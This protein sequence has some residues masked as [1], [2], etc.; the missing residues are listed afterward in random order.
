MEK[1][2][3]LPLF[4]T[5]NSGIHQEAVGGKARIPSTQKMGAAGTQIDVPLVYKD[6]S[7][8]ASH[9]DGMQVS[10][11][12]LPPDEIVVAVVVTDSGRPPYKESPVSGKRMP[13]K[14][15]GCGNP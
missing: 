13:R 6:A 12:M 14:R 5:Q 1:V 3:T 9:Y 10:F 11:Q 2:S 4:C 15:T 7:T 8:V